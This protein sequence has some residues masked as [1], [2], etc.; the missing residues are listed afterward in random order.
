[1]EQKITHLCSKYNLGNLISKPVMVTGG[2]MH[3]MYRVKTDKGEYAI[4]VLNPDIMQRPDAVNN[5]VNSERISHA[6]E[7]EGIPLI[8]AKELEGKHVLESDHAHYM[9]FEWLDGKS[10]FAP[11]ISEY[12]CE[13]I[14]EI[15]GKIHSS[16]I[17]LE[18]I[19]REQGSRALVDWDSFFE[20]AKRQDVSWLFAYEESLLQ[21]KRWDRLV[22]ESMPQLSQY[23]VIS[24][25]DL[26]PKNVMWKCNKP[27]IIDWEAAGY[28][29]PFQELIEVLN[30]WTVDENGNYDKIK[31]TALLYAYT[32]KVDITDVDW[33]AVKSGSFD[34]MIGWLAY[35]VKRALRLEGSSLNDRKEGELQLIG[36][37]QE[38]RRQ[39][40]RMEQLKTLLL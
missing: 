16:A 22:V 33:A 1:M 9:V 32:K 4:K 13:Q 36:T 34:G 26:D 28:V 14:G 15:L 19:E 2:L 21:I 20:E 38:L 8:A 18:S 24:H 40:A 27:F 12:H 23:Q 31:F 25:R 10:I 6:L 37:I 5:M 7:R 29:N 39:E 30:Y 11:N 3:K 17:F 35:N